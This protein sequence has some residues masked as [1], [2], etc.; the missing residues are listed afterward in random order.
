[1]RLEYFLLIDRVVSIDLEAG[2]IVCEST[3]P[4]ESPVFEGH[5]PRYP[6]LPGVLM[7]E[8]MAQCAGWLLVVANKYQRMPFLAAVRDAKFRG[9][10]RPGKTLIAEAKRS[11]DGSGYAMMEATLTCDGRQVCNGTITFHI[12]PFPSP[13]FEAEMRQRA[14]SIGLLGKEALADG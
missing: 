7:I 14:A 11:H 10:V 3:V 4:T 8:T 2:K 1:M 9:F 13:D 12:A 5:F 6:L